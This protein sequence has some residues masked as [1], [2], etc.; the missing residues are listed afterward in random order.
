MLEPSFPVVANRL[1]FLSQRMRG[2]GKVRGKGT[3]RESGSRSRRG[4]GEGDRV[5]VYGRLRS[6]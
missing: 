6:V 2:R 3:M 1:F 5:K 4:K